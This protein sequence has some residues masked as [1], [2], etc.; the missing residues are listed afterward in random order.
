M[1]I[2]ESVDAG[3]TGLFGQW[4]GYSTGLMTLLVAVMTYRIMSWRDPDV[5][6]MLLARQSV[7]SMVRNEGESAVYRSQA[8]PHGMP[9]CSGLNVK[10]PGVSKWSRGRDGDLRDIWRRA[11]SGGD[12]GSK[13][14]VL[15]VLGSE[16]VVQ[17]RLG[18]QEEPAH[19]PVPGG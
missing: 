3:V 11:A 5:H 4:N 16:K 10:D 1:G 18:E 9:L 13:G 19:E 17:H 8:A 12:D 2:L 15:T 6:P 14:R 7:A